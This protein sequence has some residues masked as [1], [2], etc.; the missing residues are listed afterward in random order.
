LKSTLPSEPAF[1]DQVVL[2]ITQHRQ[3]GTMV[4]PWEVNPEPGG[5]F[6]LLNRL[7]WNSTENSGSGE[8]DALVEIVSLSQTLTDAAIHK[9]FGRKGV[10]LKAFLSAIPDEL[11]QF[12]IRPY[13]E[14]Q[15]DK[16]LRLAL[17]L[18]IPVFEQDG[19]SRVYFNN[20]LELFQEPAEPWFC[21]TKTSEGSNYLLE[22]YQDEKPF[23]L[24][25]PG[26]RIISKTPCW[27]LSENRLVHLPDGFD[28]R[29]IEPFLSKEVILIPASAEKK[30]FETFILKTLKT[31]QVRANGFQVQTLVPDRRME[32]SAEIDWQGKPLLVILFRYGDKRIMAG[33]SQQVFIDLQMEPEQVVF[34]RTERD[35]SWETSMI[36]LCKNRG[37]VPS[38]HSSFVLPGHTGVENIDFHHLAEWINLNS[39]FL[40]QSGIAILTDKAPVRLFSGT[41]SASIRVEPGEDWFDVRATAHFGDIEVPF[42]QLCSFLLHDIREFPLPNGEVVILPAAWFTRYGD[43]LHFSEHR[44]TSFRL[45]N[46]HSQIIRDFHLPVNDSLNEKLSQLNPTLAPK[47]N[48]PQKLQTTLRPYQ[49]DGLQWL[50]FL[51]ENRFGG[52]LAD[53]MGLGKTIQTLALLLSLND[54]PHPASLIVMPA[55]LVHNWRNEIRR[56]APSLITLEHTGM[57]RMTTPAFFSA[58]H[59]VLTTYGTLRNDLSLFLQYRFHYIIL[60]ESQVIK[61]PSAQIS[62]AVCQL[63]AENRLVLTGTPIENSLIDL[64]SQMEFLNPGMLGSLASFQKRYSTR[65]LPLENNRNQSLSRDNPDPFTESS[66]R[67]RKLVAPFILRRTKV[68]AEPDLPPLTIKEHLCEMAEDQQTRYE[69][70]KSA[71]RNEVLQQLESGRSGETSLMVLKALIRL[72]QMAN[73]PAL[74]DPD[75]KG[76]SGKFDEIMEVAQ[77]LHEEGHKTLIFSSF[78]K[79]LQLVARRFDELGFPYVMLTGATTKRESVVTE[80][81]QDPSTQ[82]FLISLKAGGTGLNLTEAGYVMLLDPWWNPA[83]EL[84]AIN[85]A[86]RIGQDKKV[87]AYKFIS[88]GTIEEKMLALQERKQSLSDTFLPSGNPLKDM[89][90]AEIAELFR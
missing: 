51:Y 31:G 67:L 4:F 3:L 83:T 12:Q 5:W 6:T 78:V 47:I 60:D 55:S 80:F 30:Y 86:H 73:H 56:Y 42:T 34:F 9:T 22:I 43:L 29:K 71:V 49:S 40:S 7:N 62:R 26:N 58:A 87:I 46:Y 53:D 17:A 57:Q 84:Q 65:H 50:R 44:E 64:W 63:K 8:A 11:L 13:I 32:L 68:E 85:R 1:M 36:D 89:T 88:S 72:R 21:F 90:P 23:R 24:K 75:Y 41:V 77:T 14:K 25:H 45:A 18:H 16:I 76:T 39:T 27:F 33:K 69:K 66:E 54:E 61:N 10:S 20:R 2:L 15:T 70:E 74:A 59:V 52:C 37:L 79:H 19:P 38:G 81:R 48:S 28:G 35:A 82:F